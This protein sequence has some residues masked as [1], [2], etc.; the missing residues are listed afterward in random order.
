ML[1][2]RDH[3][4]QHAGR[5]IDRDHRAAFL[6]QAAGDVAAAGGDVEHLHVRAGL[7]PFDEQVEVGALAVGRALTERVGPLRPQVGHAAAS[8]TARC[9]ASNIVGSTWRFEGAASASSR[10]PSSA[11]VPSSRT[12]IGNSIRICSSAAR[13]PRATSSPRV[14]PPKMLK[15]IERTWLSLVITSSASTTPCASPPP[16]RSQKFA[17]LPPA[18]TTTSTVDIER[19]AP[20]PRIPTSP[21]SLT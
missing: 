16:P 6:A 18:T 3:I 20:F 9:A 2:G 19:P 14:I 13:I 7:A 4:G 11:F 21:S 1:G 12:T 8:S 10:R 5:G 15:K 17:G